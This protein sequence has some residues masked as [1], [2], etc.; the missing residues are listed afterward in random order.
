MN[1]HLH[2]TWWE[3]NSWIKAN[4]IQVRALLLRM[5]IRL[6][7]GWEKQERGGIKSTECWK[8]GTTRA[9]LLLNKQKVSNNLRI[10]VTNWIL[11]HHSNSNPRKRVGQKKCFLKNH[12]KATNYKEETLLIILIIMV[13]IINILIS[14]RIRESAIVVCWC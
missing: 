1:A 13:G 5:L 3:P 2:L 10:T 8:E 9:S 12:S 11:S 7:W 14:K 6:Y 4:R